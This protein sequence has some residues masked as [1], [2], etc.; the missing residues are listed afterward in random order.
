MDHFFTI[1]SS[2]ERHLGCFYFLDIVNKLKWVLLYNYLWSRIS[3][4][5]GIC[6]EV[7]QQIHMADFFLDFWGFSALISR[8][9]VH[10]C[11]FTN[12]ERG[13]PSPKISPAF[14][15]SYFLDIRHSDWDKKKHQSCI[16]LH[17][18]SC[19]RWTFLKYFLAIFIY[20]T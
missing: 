7:I 20:S 14:T 13:F 19:W 17:F 2:I 12:S 5:F 15:T 9:V 4:P 8:V 3:S 6:Q 11:I 10:V 16:Y 1:Y 18:F